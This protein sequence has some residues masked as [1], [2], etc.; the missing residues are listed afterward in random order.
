MSSLV[1]YPFKK[2]HLTIPV[3]SSLFF[4][5]DEAFKKRFYNELLLSLFR[6]KEMILEREIQKFK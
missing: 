6:F 2:A 1:G 5:L 4:T 3:E